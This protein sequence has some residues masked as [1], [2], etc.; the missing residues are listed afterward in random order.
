MPDA[1][2]GTVIQPA[3]SD[4]AYPSPGMLLDSREREPASYPAVAGATDQSWWSSVW[5][6]PVEQSTRLG[7]T[8]LGSSDLATSSRLSGVLGAEGVDQDRAVKFTWPSGSVHVY[9]REEP[10]LLGMQLDGGPV[11]L[12]IGPALLGAQTWSLDVGMANVDNPNPAGED[13]EIPF[14]GAEPSNVGRELGP[15]GID[16]IVKKD[17]FHVTQILR[18]QEGHES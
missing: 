14:G 11:G 3:S 17:P 13:T 2:H 6:T 7:G 9:A 15:L 18:E 4:R 16:Q 5:Q 8:Y 10:G 1:V 12:R